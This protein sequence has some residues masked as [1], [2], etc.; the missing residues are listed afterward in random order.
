MIGKM[1]QTLGRTALM[2]S[3]SALALAGCD[4]DSDDGGSAGSGGVVGG[5]GGAGGAVGGAGGAGA[6][7]GATDEPEQLTFDI[8]G[9]QIGEP[10]GVA[11][12]L[13]TLLNRSFRDDTVIV[14]VQ[15]DGWASGDITV[16]GGA[17]QYIEGKETEALA[18]NIFTWLT[19]G[20]CINLEGEAN[21]CSVDVGT[22]GASRDGN[23]FTF[24][25]KGDLNIYSDD[26]KLIIPLKAVE[27]EGEVI[28]GVE[29]GEPDDALALIEADLRGYITVADAEQTLFEL[30][31]GNPDTQRILSEL[32]DDL[33]VERE[34]ISI[35]GGDPEEA[36]PLAGT[37]TGI[38]AGFSL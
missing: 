7:G 20:Q 10:E 19:E 27:I 8:D 11:N 14:L 37:I 15:L 38:Q 25:D 16:N 34:M 17:G 12:I 3:L 22:L 23:N 32:F 18:D 4:D 24:T 31:P 30:V 5:A 28:P 13:G 1:T 21:P 2:I 6:G 26:L 9:I 35:E 29:G 36:Y 33:G